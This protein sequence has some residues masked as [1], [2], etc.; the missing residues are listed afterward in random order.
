MSHHHRNHK[1]H[2]TLPS[3]ADSKPCVGGAEAC[4]ATPAAADI[5]LRAFE[6]SQARHGTPGNAQADW[7][8]AEQ[9]LQ[10]GRNVKN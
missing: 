2:D 1:A 9:E 8:Q 5:R 10:A 3:I 6:I 4:C 7:T